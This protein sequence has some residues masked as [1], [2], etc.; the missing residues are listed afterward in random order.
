MTSMAQE[1]DGSAGSAS[2]Y[3]GEKREIC[4]LKQAVF[5]TNPFLG[6]PAWKGFHM[7]PLLLGI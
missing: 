5:V 7:T 3:F 2:G 6:L 4:F 1:D